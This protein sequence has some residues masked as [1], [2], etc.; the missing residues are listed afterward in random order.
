MYTCTYMCVYICVFC[1]YLSIY[2][3]IHLPTYLSVCLPIYSYWIN[4]LAT[5]GPPSEAFFPKPHPLNPSKNNTSPGDHFPEST[6][7]HGGTLYPS[8]YAPWSKHG[9]VVRYGHPTIRDS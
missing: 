6:D 5:L 3:S 8:A 7:G 9:F 4:Q 2:S 1:K